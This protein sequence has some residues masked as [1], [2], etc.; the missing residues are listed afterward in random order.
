MNLNRIHGMCVLI[1]VFC[2]GEMADHQALAAN[3]DGAADRLFQLL[4]GN[5]NSSIDPTEWTQARTLRKW[6]NFQGMSPT[7]SV[8]KDQFRTLFR[9][10]MT[11]L[12]QRGRANRQ[13]SLSPTKENR[14]KL[15][16]S[17]R[18]ENSP[19][20][21]PKTAKKLT[22]SVLSNDGSRPLN[23][24]GKKKA[25]RAA[26]LGT[27]SKVPLPPRFRAN[28]ENGDG[29]LGYHEW[30]SLDGTNF[31]ILDKNHD[32]FLTT[33]ELHERYPSTKPKK[34]KKPKKTPTKSLPSKYRRHDSDADGQIGFYEWEPDD[35]NGFDLLDRNQDGFLTPLE[36]GVNRPKLRRV[37]RM[38]EEG[39][40]Q[41]RASIM[42]RRMDRN[43][44]GTLDFTEIGQSEIM[45]RSYEREGTAMPTSLSYREF[46]DQYLKIEQP[47]L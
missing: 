10:F 4:D 15:V 7:E 46:V 2:C 23:M 30:S 20:S 9:S 47:E 45:R 27:R 1:V 17:F 14:S 34:T 6:L 36:L 24:S 31:R 13:S 11:E 22:F 39:K 8:K 18:T 3:R 26:M 42:F 32:G 19:Q 33:N 44:N 35:Q 37:K 29:R 38:S 21:T 25:K 43:R 12:R 5:K 41:K 40:S 16:A 28:D